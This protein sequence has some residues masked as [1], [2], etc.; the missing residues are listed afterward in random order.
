VAHVEE[1]IADAVAIAE[2]PT[3]L[4]AARHSHAANLRVV[5]GAPN[6]VRGGSHSGNVAAETLAR[7]GVLDILSSDY[8]P[9]S[10]LLGAFEIARRI[11]G[12]GLPRAV[13]TVTLNPARAAG[14]ADRGEI[15]PGKRADLVRVQ[16]VDDMPLVREVYRDGRR[17]A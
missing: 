6:L 13:Q 2:F 17:V 10:L 1:S 9:V 3:T 7:E 16:V 12:Y 5:M 8:V 4:E 15:A 11:E 14:L